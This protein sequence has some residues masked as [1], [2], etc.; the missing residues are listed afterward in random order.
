MKIYYETR[1]GKLYHG[2]CLEVMQELEDNFVDTVITDP[3]YGLRFMGEKWDYDV[4]SMDIWKEALRVLKPGG[5]ALI[6]AGSRTQHRMAVRVEDAGFVLKDVIM[7]LYST[8]FPKGTDIGKQIDKKLGNKREYI[9]TEIKS[10][11][12]NGSTYAW[13]GC[14]DTGHCH[15]SKGNS[16]WDGW[17]SH[18]LKPAYEPIILA[19]KPNDGSYADNAL[20]WGVSGLNIESC[21]TQLAPPP[22]EQPKLGVRDRRTYGFGTGT[23]RNGKISRPSGRYPANIIHD[24]SPAVKNIFPMTKTG[25]NKPHKI[26]RKKIGIDFCSGLTHTI[27]YFKGYEG[28]AADFFYCAKASKSEREAGFAELQKKMMVRYGEK[29]QGPLPK[30]TPNKP[31][32]QSNHHPTVKPLS[33]MKY[34][35]RLTSTPT[36]GTGIDLFAGSGTTLVACELMGRRWIGIEQEEE[37]CEIAAKRIE[38]AA[39]E[40]SNFQGVK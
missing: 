12:K 20:K 9:E 8:G 22:K 4:P 31:T 18:C 35:C 24:G 36:G 10:P 38:N 6:F 27:N 40:N 33:L 25:D 13:S 17:K 1:L 29:G 37:Y 15:V 3:P 34:L 23:G 30:Q 32:A 26:N 5:T 14:N 2:D 7:W 19:M 39:K 21:R 28:S 11:H 16:G